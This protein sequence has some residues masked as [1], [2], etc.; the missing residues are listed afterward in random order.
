[1]SYIQGFVIPVPTA[2]KDAFI[3]HARKAD[4]VFIEHGALKI[5][6]CWGS[7]VPHGKVT[8]FYGAVAAKDDETVVFSWIEW[9]DKAT[10]EAMHA[11]MD[12]LTKTDPRFSMESNPPPFDGK[13]MIYGGFE[14]VV[15]LGE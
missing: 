4:E 12:E 7:D 11:K 5:W 3:A 6:E 14:P 2:S 1:M 10:S 9:P 15:I 13:R 8:D